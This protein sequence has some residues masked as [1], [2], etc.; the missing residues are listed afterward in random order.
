MRT[1]AAACCGFTLTPAVQ[2]SPLVESPYPNTNAINFV[3]GRC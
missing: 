2:G 3:S 1:A